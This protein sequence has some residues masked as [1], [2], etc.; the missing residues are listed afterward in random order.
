MNKQKWII[1]M[2]ALGLIGGTSGIL[3]HA[4][5]HQRLGLPGIKTL[6]IPGSPRLDIQLPSLVLDY[7]AEVLPVDDLFLRYM[8]QD[9]SVAQRRYTAADG[10]PI[11]VNAVLMGADRTSLHKP[12][13][14]LTGQGWLIDDSKTVTTSIPMQLPQPYDLPVRRFTVTREVPVHDKQETFK[15]VYIFWFVADNELAANHWR[16]NWSMARQVLTTGVLQRW[17][18]VACFAACH[19]GEEEATSQRLEKFIQAAAPQFQLVPGPRN[20]GTAV[21]QSASNQFR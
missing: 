14:C 2:L 6:P 9:T 17:A 5:A 11:L 16:R 19:P 8:P 3:A 12:E 15:G 7:K 13:F 21:A 20:A 10:Y 4:R 1:L 18:Y